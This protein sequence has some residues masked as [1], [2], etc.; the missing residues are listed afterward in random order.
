[1]PEV[2]GT[3]KWKSN[4]N[5]ETLT[6]TL[7]N[8]IGG[9]T[10]SPW[11]MM[12][13]T[14]NASSSG[15]LIAVVSGIVPVNVIVNGYVPSKGW[16]YTENGVFVPYD[17][18][19][20]CK[21]EEP[22]VFPEDAY[23]WTFVQMNVIKTTIKKWFKATLTIP[24]EWDTSIAYNDMLVEAVIKHGE[25][26]TNAPT[27]TVMIPSADLNYLGA[28]NSPIVLYKNGKWTVREPVSFEYS[29]DWIP[30][31]YIQQFMDVNLTDTL[32]AITITVSILSPDG[33]ATRLTRTLPQVTK[34][35]ASQSDG[36]QYFTFNS[37]DG[38][39][40]NASYEI[41]TVTGKRLAGYST[42]P[43]SLIPEFPAVTNG[44]I[45]VNWDSDTVLYEVW[46]RAA[47][48]PNTTFSINLYKSSA[49][50]K[51]VNKADYLTSVGTISGA[52]RDVCDVQSPTILLEYAKFP[53][54]NYVY[55]PAFG[56]RYYFVDK[57]VSAGKNL[58]NITFTEDV[59][60][61][62][63][64]GILKLSAVIERQEN[65]YNL[66]LRDPLLPAQQNFTY[67]IIDSTFSFPFTTSGTSEVPN[68]ILTVVGTGVNDGPAPTS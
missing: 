50:R 61:S 45:D 58:W 17:N 27:L 35:Q 57:Y 9:T 56:G 10:E 63:K 2:Y 4:P 55:I 28:D 23:E 19:R 47:P 44:K 1:M 59:L 41:P 64:T 43:N 25:C 31:D 30:D 20:I 32:P 33:S 62:F 5:I 54:F 34:Y 40:Q 12:N 51:R 37:A 18:F 53:D 39:F 22:A 11:G 13:V 24:P 67:S 3:Y 60:M 14:Y 16:G 8:C 49:E 26:I 6:S 7:N 48:V 66:Q 68:C 38:S 46:D 21:V 36:S 65:V 15:I 42:Q 52:L 29:T